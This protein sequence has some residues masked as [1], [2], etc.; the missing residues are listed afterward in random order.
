MKQMQKGFTLIELM[1]VVAIIGILAAVA[2]PQYQDYVTRTKLSNAATFA[3]P[4]KTAIAEYAQENGALPTFTAA[5]GAAAGWT[6]L[7]LSG[8]PTTTTEVSSVSMA[9]GGILT[10]T[11]SVPVSVNGTVTSAPT[12]IMTPTVGPT[13][14]T[15]GNACTPTGSANMI[16]EFPGCS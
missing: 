5:N 16:K 15:W 11:L 13:S 9:S 10:L 7:G 1:I 14:V 4:I 6:S 12:V 2:I 3:N 8:A